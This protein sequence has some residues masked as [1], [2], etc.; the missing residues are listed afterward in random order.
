MKRDLKFSN[1]NF[2]FQTNYLCLQEVIVGPENRTATSKDNFLKVNLIGDFVG[3]TSIPTF[4]DFYLVIPRQVS[5]LRGYCYDYPANRYI[6]VILSVTPRW[7]FPWHFTRWINI[8]RLFG[9]FSYL[10]CRDRMWSLKI[11]QKYDHWTIILI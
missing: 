8:I 9:L 1:M 11:L 3:Y 10:P 5:L 4:E 7:F 2:T 6:L